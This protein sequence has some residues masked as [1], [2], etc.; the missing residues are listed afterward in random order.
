MSGPLRS[1]VGF[2]PRGCEPSGSLRA[3]SGRCQPSA[4]DRPDGT[5]LVPLPAF[6]DGE[7]RLLEHPQRAV[8]GIGWRRSSRPPCPPGRPRAWS[9][10]SLGRSRSPRRAGRWRRPD[11]GSSCDTTKHTMDQTGVSSIGARI[12]EWAS[13]PK[14][15]R[16]PRLTQPTTR[17]SRYASRPGAM[18]RSARSA[19]SARLPLAVELVQSRPRNRKY[20]HQ[21]HFGSPPS[22]NS[23]ARSGKRSVVSGRMSGAGSVTPPMLRGGLGRRFRR[24]IGRWVWGGLRRGIGRRR[25]SGLRRRVRRRLRGRVRCR[26][27]GRAARR[28][29]GLDRAGGRRRA[30]RPSRSARSCRPGRPRPASPRWPG[31]SRR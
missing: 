21:H 26:G 19:S 31:R 28:C 25:W 5:G 14:S 16:G 29:R 24:G 20:V 7:A 18:S 1:R 22:S 12:F 4:D 6:G 11:L 2:W 27:R 30:C 8:I 23:A 3:R 10:R 13:R 17:S 9:H 15:S